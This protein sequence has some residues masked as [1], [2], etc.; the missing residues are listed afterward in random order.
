MQIDPQHPTNNDNSVDQFQSI[1][2]AGERPEGNEVSR[3]FNISASV[4]VPVAGKPSLQRVIAA[5]D[6]SESV[7]GGVICGPS[8]TAIEKSDELSQLLEMTDHKWLKPD[9]GPAAS[10][11][12]ALQ[13]LNHYPALLTAGDHALLTSDI[14]D[15]F[16]KLALTHSDRSQFDIVIGFVPYA[17]VKAAWPESKRTVLKFSN[18]QFCGSNLFAVLTPEGANA[19]KFWRQAEADRKKPWKIAKRFGILPLIMYLFRRLSIEDAL[20]GLSSAANCKVGYVTVNFAR[21]AVDVDSIADQKLA[22]SI[23]RSE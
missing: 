3:A 22:E 16:C 20:S 2:L 6:K 9:T 17:L 7:R 1:I 11:F 10:A 15:E 14:V 18:G 5:I 13:Q 8:Q 12:A 19:L 4:M 23:L 21:A